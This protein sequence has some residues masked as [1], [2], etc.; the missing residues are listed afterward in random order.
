MIDKNRRNRRFKKSI[1]MQYCIAGVYPKKWDMSII[2]NIS[3]GGVKFSAPSDLQLKGKI[4]QLQIK[5]PELAPRLLEVEAMVLDTQPRF[6]AKYCDVRAKFIN[7][8]D[9]NK[10]HLS[11]VEK[12]IEKNSDRH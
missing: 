1:N 4:V 7:L 9:I 8:T 11:I 6:N 5:I 12:M 10:E 2:D 3:I